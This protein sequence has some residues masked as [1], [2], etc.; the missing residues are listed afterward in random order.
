[1]RKTSC[2]AMFGALA[3]LC[4]AAPAMAAPPLDSFDVDRAGIT[5]SGISSGGYMAQQFHVAYSSLVRGAGIV[6]GGPYDC[7]K[8]NVAIALTA[9]TT[10][11]LLNPPKA[12]ESI[13]ATE[14][15]AARGLVDPVVNLRTSRVWLFSG[16][17]DETVYP[18]VMDQLDAYVRHYVDATNVAYVKTVPAAHSMVTDGY[19]FACDHKGDGNDAADTFINDCRYDAAGILLAH[20]YSPLAPK[21]AT[22]TGHLVPF[23]QAE[24]IADPVAHSMSA[25]GWAYVPRACDGGATCRVHVAFH[26]CQQYPERIGDAYRAH[27]GYNTW[28]DTNRI[29][30]LYPSATA[31]PLP[32][33]Y[34]P[35][36][37]WD[38]WGYDDAGYA[39]RDGRQMKAVKAM[40]DRLSAGYRP[41]LPVAPANVRTT[42]ATPT[43][44]DVAWDASPSARI[45]R[46]DVYAAADGGDFV[47]V[48]STT[49]TAV[50]V[51]PLRVGGAYRFVV[52]TVDRLDRASG[53]SNTASGATAAV[54]PL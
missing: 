5:V 45:D 52:R 35:K 12:S 1:M 30:V 37:C 53:D 54:R 23:A 6:A 32:P 8:G 15:N 10:P 25:D 27:A 33:V 43:T 26:G 24:F 18:V 22:P 17:K 47:R 41:G 19:G 4:G 14:S 44:V 38:W 29:V 51:G 31:S 20:L 2:T 7:A 36:G 9:C 46:Y 50:T 21:A 13:A 28:A 34:N 16:A 42:G 3:L 48:A 40:I 11:T 49:A 39:T